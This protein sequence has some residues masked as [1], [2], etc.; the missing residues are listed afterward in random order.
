MV[1]IVKS[2]NKI[3]KSNNKNNDFI[4]ATKIKNY[5]LKDPLIDWLSYYKIYDINNK[6]NK[7]RKKQ[8]TTDNFL[9]YIFNEGKNYEK[10]IMDNLKSQYEIKTVCKN[11]EFYGI[12]KFEET[13]QLMNI[14]TNIIYQ[15]M[16]YNY[17]NKTFGIPDLLIRSDFIN[18]MFEN[19]IPIEEELV[20][21]KFYYIVVDI[22]SST[23]QLDCKGHH[24]LNSNNLII[25]KGQ[26]LIY[27]LALS[28]IFNFKINKAFILGKRF[29]WISNNIKYVEN[30]PFKKLGLID[31]KNIDFHYYE[32][33]D[34][35]LLWINNVKTFGKNWKVLPKPSKK[36]LYPNMKNSK[37]NGYRKVKTQ[38]ANELSELTSLWYVSVKNRENA[39][40][41]NIFSWKDK[42]CSSQILEI[43]N[44]RGEILDKIMEINRSDTDIIYP[45]K[46]NYDINN[47]KVI[48][49]NT[50]EFYID[51]ETNCTDY[52]NYIFMI[53]VGFYNAKW[54]F[55]NFTM[56]QLNEEC[57]EDIFKEF[58]DYINNI[59]LKYNK[60]TSRFIHWTKAEPIS[61]NKS[62]DKFKL[63]TKNF[64]DLYDVFINEPIVI[65]GAL[66]FSLKEIAKA[67][68][69]LGLIESIWPK[70][71]LCSNGSDALLYSIQ[72]YK[73]GRKIRKTNKILCD[74][75][76]YNE[77]DCK[78]LFEII[79]YL[80]NNNI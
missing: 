44:K 52:T 27:T 60:T 14:G 62:I 25:Y 37:D 39:H 26:L 6:P 75:I 53:G 5:L 2:N 78:V 50:L 38:I 11:D 66:N 45:P 1:K 34:N 20:N 70:N 23:I 65:K 51:Y 49:E 63:P 80:R 10:Y 69:N 17:K 18:K 61:Y 48:E 35:A 47:W 3:V 57:Q 4:S 54:E 30:N 77:I 22:K 15:G 9:E 79:T 59:L 58:W 16:L 36:E 12:D 13:K 33:I 21:N 68:Y 41:N 67:C 64:I 32:L 46:I 29:S 8:E 55:K 31:Y 19:T 42:R 74:I 71:T 72:L 73:S 43:K 40:N 76:N 28:E 7:N 24:I 56:V